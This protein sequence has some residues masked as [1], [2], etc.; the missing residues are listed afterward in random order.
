MRAE[1][2]DQREERLQVLVEARRRV[3]HS[4]RQELDQRLRHVQ[5]QYLENR[6]S[7]HRILFA[8]EPY[9][10]YNNSKTREFFLGKE[11]NPL[12]V[13]NSFPG[14]Q[15]EKSTIISTT[16]TRKGRKTSIKRPAP[17]PKTNLI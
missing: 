1:L 5:I 3:A 11:K 17:R 14:T 13:S 12:T 7:Y 10:Q 6:T 4:S 8:H 9:F 15:E 2:A 16:Q